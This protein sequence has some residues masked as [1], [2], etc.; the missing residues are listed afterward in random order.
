[1]DW[2]LKN[3]FE[4]ISTIAGLIYLY[5][6]IKQKIWLWPLGIIASVYSAMVFYHSQ[7][8]ADMTLNIYYIFVSIYGWLHWVLNKDNISHSS[9]KISV[10]SLKN[11]FEYLAV[12]AIITIIF[13]LVLIYIPEKIGIK[14][15]AIPWCDA[16]LTSASIVATWMLARKVLEQWLWWIVIDGLTIG[17]LIYKELYIM[18]G[19]FVVY[20]IMAVVGFYKWKEDLRNNA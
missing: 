5:F 20:T 6:S 10:L 8:Y 16:F 11:W 15:S 19:L 17:V 3:H 14:P 9:L 1:V 12:V 2:I 7:L 4:I 18:S 13:A